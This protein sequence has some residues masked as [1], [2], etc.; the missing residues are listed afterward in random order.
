MLLLSSAHSSQPNNTLLLQT[1][2]R[3]FS[4]SFCPLATRITHDGTHT[5][6]LTDVH[7]S[8]RSGHRFLTGGDYLPTGI[9]LTRPS[10]AA[11]GEYFNPL[12]L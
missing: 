1:P 10:P 11:L 4:P 2:S 6:I 5:P 3:S 7:A 12:A 9:S 8:S